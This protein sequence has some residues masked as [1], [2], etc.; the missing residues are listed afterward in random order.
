MLLQFICVIVLVVS[1]LLNRMGWGDPKL[2]LLGMGVAMG[3]WLILAIYVLLSSLWAMYQQSWSSGGDTVIPLVVAVIPIVLVA[4]LVVRSQQVPSIHDI[5]TDTQRPPVFVYAQQVRHPSHNDI[6]YSS[7]NAPLQAQ[8]YPDIQPLSLSIAPMDVL[9]LVEQL[10]NELGWQLQGV[11]AAGT[12]VEAYDTSALLGFVDDV[13]I[14][15]TPIQ[16]DGGE[17]S[18][19][20]VRS[21]SRIGVSDLGANAARIAAFLKQLKGMPEVVAQ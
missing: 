7:N 20:D 11:N 13:V 21:A 5:T 1:L 15:I 18:L 10:V 3:V 14:R 8:A 2:P 16:G 9:L 19:V 17:G 6:L 12:V 4:A